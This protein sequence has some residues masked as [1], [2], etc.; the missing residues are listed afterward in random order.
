MFSSLYETI[1]GE[2]E[3]RAPEESTPSHATSSVI[4]ALDTAAMPTAVTENGHPAHTWVTD[5]A[6][7]TAVRERFVQ[8]F[9]QLVRPSPHVRKEKLKSF[10][11]AYTS[12]VK[13]TQE[14]PESP[15][16][17][18]LIRILW[19]LPTHTRD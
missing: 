9:F 19:N 14:L 4:D 10:A 17:D 12:I 8:L 7:I 13:D 3:T 2:S 11:D 15:D 5:D 18:H 6:T 1:F 16:R